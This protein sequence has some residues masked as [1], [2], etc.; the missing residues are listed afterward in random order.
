MMV[1]A[2]D[3]RCDMTMM[4]M[5]ILITLCHPGEDYSWQPA[6]WNT[7]DHLGPSWRRLLHVALS[8]SVRL[9]GDV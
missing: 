8:R 3:K 5:M 6:L 1:A 4:N 2:D 9:R 7:V